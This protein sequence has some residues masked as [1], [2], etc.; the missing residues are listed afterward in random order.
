VLAQAVAAAVFAL[1]GPL[2]PTPIG[3][4]PRFHPPASPHACGAPRPRT[5][6]RVHLELFAQGRV[7]IVPG[8]ICA[9]GLR[10]TAPTGVVEVPRGARVTL[11]DFFRAWTQPLSRSRLLTFSGRVYA[12]VSGEP[13]RGDVR[14]IPLTRHAQIV[15][16][17]GPRIPPHRFF[18]FGARR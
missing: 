16:E 9:R 15:L 7:V 2:I 12:F 11:G 4:G 1:Q 17:V 8:R 13:W 18:L 6:D 5:V 3:V 10:T 14:A